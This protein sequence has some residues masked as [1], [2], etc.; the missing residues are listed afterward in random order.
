MNQKTNKQRKDRNMV[1]F[2]LGYTLPS[3]DVLEKI[4]LGS[5]L[6]EGSAINEVAEILKPEVFYQ[7]QHKAIYTAI[8]EIYRNGESIDMI[9][10][11]EKLKKSGNLDEVGGLMY[12]SE[13]TNHVA[14]AVNIQNHARYLH[15]LFLKRSLYMATLEINKKSVD[16]TED[17]S[18]TL[19]EALKRIEFISMQTEYGVNSEDLRTLAR[20]CIENYSKRKEAAQNG[21]KTGITTG[22]TRLDWATSG[23]Q[24]GQLIILAA[25]PAMGKTAM[26]LHFAKSAAQAGSSV[27][28]FSLEMNPESLTDRLILSA[29]GINSESYRNGVLTEEEESKVCNAFNDLENLP[30]T[31]DR[32]A[33]I[34]LHQIKARARNHKAKNKCDLILIDYLQLIDMRQQNRTY[35]REQEIS[36]TSRAA[37]IMAKELCVPVIILSQLSRKVEER[38]NKKPLLS[39]LRES[40]AI[41]QDADMVLFIHREEYYSSAA[42][43]G[44]GEI[45]VA[46]QREGRTGEVDFSYSTNLTQ[47]TD[48]T[49]W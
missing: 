40:G 15:D 37:K 36:Q 5:L 9:V 19:N 7:D 6:L 35:N 48:Y 24:P 49:S 44:K 23:W 18:D 4:I 2:N 3:D 38:S 17:I 14:S 16:E 43:A 27:L 34:S 41:E 10:V 28:I 1:N 47:I 11:S 46:K 8:E 39:D 22:L 33:N 31:V 29:S 42:E 26:M 13:L 25:R 30:I 12:I 45:I 20:R 32:T 21:K